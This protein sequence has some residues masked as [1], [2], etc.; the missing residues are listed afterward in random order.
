MHGHPQ[1]DWTP[2][3]I[4][5]ADEFAANLTRRHTAETM[6]CKDI[7]TE[8]L[9]AGI[10]QTAIDLWIYTSNEREERRQI[11]FGKEAG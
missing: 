1:D 7:S 8:A 11:V 10:V 6:A 5:S 9:E 4:K 2:E 3:M